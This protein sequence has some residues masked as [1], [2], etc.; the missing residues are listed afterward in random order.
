MQIS[1]EVGG[2]VAQQLGHWIQNRTV[3]NS[4]FSWCTTK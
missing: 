2:L 1:A 4:I 3:Q